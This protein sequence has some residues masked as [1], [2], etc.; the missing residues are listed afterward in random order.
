MILEHVIDMLISFSTDKIFIVSVNCEF[1]RK[2]LH[3]RLNC[4][5]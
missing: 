4:Y 3:R 2:R 5:F 1:W